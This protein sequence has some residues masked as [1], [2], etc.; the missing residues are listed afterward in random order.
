MSTSLWLWSSAVTFLCITVSEQANQY[1]CQDITDYSWNQPY[2]GKRLDCSNKTF[3]SLDS[4]Y[5]YPERSLG[6]LS[7]LWLNNSGITSLGYHVFYNM[8]RLKYLT[9]GRNF[10]DSLDN[11]VFY[12]LNDLQYL[13]LSHNKL[14]SVN[15]VALFVSQ[16]NLRKLLLG[17]NRLTTLTKMIF[18]HM[19]KLDYLEL[20]YNNL[21]HLADNLF[22]SQEHLSTVLLGGNKL[23]TIN[24]TLLRPLRSIRLLDLSENPLHFDCNLRPAVLWCKDMKLHTRAIFYSLTSVQASKWATL[25]TL[26]NC[27]ENNI[28]DVMFPASDTNLTN[29]E[30]ISLSI[31][32]ISLVVLGIVTFTV[33]QIMCCGLMYFKIRQRCSVSAG[34]EEIM[35]CDRSCNHIHHYDYVTSPSTSDLP[36]LPA[37]PTPCANSDKLHTSTSPEP[38]ETGHAQSAALHTGVDLIVPCLY[39]RNELYDEWLHNVEPDVTESRRAHDEIPENY[40]SGEN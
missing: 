39:I 6:Q 13:D 32:S 24:V 23:T 10:L 27:S 37:R 30:Y 38:E 7:D 2:Q 20:S 34:Q 35:L 1:G 19:T 8:N 15:S 5:I 22:S 33:L 16:R 36:E 28:H 26:E 29:S 18:L 31:S 40:R 12:S 17:Y 21:Y 4:F 3:G 9:L 14:I 25:E 11:R